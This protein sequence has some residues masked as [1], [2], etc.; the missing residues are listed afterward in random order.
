MM[1]YAAENFSL[2][3]EVRSLRALDSVKSARL[4]AEQC[5]TELEQAFQKVVESEKPTRD[6]SGK[7]YKGDFICDLSLR[8]ASS[9]YLVST[10]HCI[11]TA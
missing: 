11:V 7:K 2:R 4:T 10:S 9:E 6:T 1:R 3:E 5:T 8:R